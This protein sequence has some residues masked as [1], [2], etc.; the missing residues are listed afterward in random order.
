M[1]WSLGHFGG[2]RLDKRGGVILEQMVTRETVCLRRLGGNRA[3]WVIARLDSWHGYGAPQTHR[4]APRA[5][6]IP[7]HTP[8]TRPDRKSNEMRACRS[9]S[10]GG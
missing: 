10:T 5:G 4:H 6:A 2:G 8:R 7:R 1:A 9:G 3:A